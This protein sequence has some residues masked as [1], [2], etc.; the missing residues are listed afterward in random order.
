V[1]GVIS[2]V[3][4]FN[5]HI[6]VYVDSKEANGGVTT[7]T[8]AT[9]PPAAAQSAATATPRAAT[10]ADPA[11]APTPRLADGH[12]DLNPTWDNGRSAFGFAPN[13]GGTTC[14]FGCAPAGGAGRGTAAANAQPQRGTARP[15]YK[16]EFIAKVKWE[17]DTLVIDAVNFNATRGSSTTAPFTLPACASWSVCAASAIRSSTKRPRTILRFWPNRG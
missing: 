8:L 16:P 12:P 11:A 10:A 14:V 3:E 9:I 15:A 2:K 13:A 5:P 17:Q 6:Y 1:T 4:W 7:W